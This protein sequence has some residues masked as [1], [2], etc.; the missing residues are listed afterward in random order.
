M[1]TLEQDRGRQVVEIFADYLAEKKD[2]YVT[3]IEELGFVLLRDL[4]GDFFDGNVVCQKAERLFEELQELWEADY[5]F[6]TGLLNGC[7]DFNSSEESL[8]SIQREEREQIRR[9]RRQKLAAI[10]NT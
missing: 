6:H 1:T 3:V 5:L 7:E 9:E 4:R 2:I 10:L 8:T